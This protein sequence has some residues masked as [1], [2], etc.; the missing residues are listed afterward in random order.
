MQKLNYDSRFIESSK[1]E[2][3]NAEPVPINIDYHIHP[4]EYKTKVT[5]KDRIQTSIFSTSEL[6]ILSLMTIFLSILGL[7]LGG[8]L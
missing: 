2:S 8:K 5:F 7:I 1:I 3:I 6:I 4:V